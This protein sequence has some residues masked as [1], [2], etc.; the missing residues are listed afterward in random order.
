[1][2]VEDIIAR[3]SGGDPNARNPN[4]SAGGLGQFIDS[5]WLDMLQRHRPDI[6][7]G[8]SRQEL[9]DLKFDPTLSKEMTEAYAADNSAILAK[10]GQPVTPGTTYLAH[11]A[12]PQTAVKVLAADPTTPVVQLL[13][14]DAVAANPFVRSMT[15]GDLRAWADGTKPKTGHIA[16]SVRPE[17]PKQNA[18]NADLGDIFTNL[19]VRPQIPLTV[20]HFG[21]Q[22]P[23]PVVGN[24]QSVDD[25]AFAPRTVAGQLKRRQVWG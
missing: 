5:T 23:P 2:A 25:P 15:A 24:G 13:N 16:P 1:M 22:L 20:P 19:A 8:R 18:Q 10:A 17:V 3:E 12:G 9:L 14:P 4:S 6:A 11:F 21:N 7:G